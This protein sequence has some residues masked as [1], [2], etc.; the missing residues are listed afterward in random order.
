VAAVDRSDAIARSAMAVA[1]MP[2]A[3][4]WGDP[5]P[6]RSPRARTFVMTTSSAP[7]TSAASPADR[8]RLLIVLLAYAALSWALFGGDAIGPSWRE[9]DTQSVARNLAFERFDVLRPQVDWRGDTSGEFEGEMPIYQAVVALCLRAA[10]DVEWPG[11]LVSLA[12]TAWLAASWFAVLL[13]LCGRRAAWFGALA[14]LGSAQA[15]HLGTRI[16]PD[17]ASLALGAAGLAAFVRFLDDGRGRTLLLAV[18]WTSLG[19]LAKP[20]SLQ[21]VALQAVF[22]LALRPAVLLQVRVWL[23]FAVA[24]A[25]TAAWIAHAHGLGRATGLTFG[26]TF[27]DVKAPNVDTLLRPA[28]WLSLARSTLAYGC[29]WLGVVAGARLLF[30]RRLDRRDIGF[31]ATVALGLV[32]SFRYSHDAG[33]GPHYHAFSALLGS[34]LIARCVALAPAPRWLGPAFAL[35]LAAVAAHACATEIAQRPGRA[36][37]SHDATAAVIRA[38]TTPSERIVVRGPKPAFDAL[39]RRPSNFEEP[40]LPYLSRRKAWLLPAD[41]VDGERLADLAA[42]GAAVYVETA[43]AGP[44]AELAAWLTANAPVL[45]RTPSATLHR[46]PSR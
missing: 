18:A 36:A 10:G 11:R 40:V 35:A 45:A 29:G 39:W 3:V 24:A 8:S 25:A 42:R 6:R 28:L 32:G 1:R 2:A 30:A 23:G 19:A 14:L 20:T 34:W 38:H 22:A 17:A 13:R 26:V 37:T 21:F 9:C 46:L 5:A 31:A 27:G 44:S 4:S 16:L 41:G 15:A 12:A 7:A 43:A 33:M